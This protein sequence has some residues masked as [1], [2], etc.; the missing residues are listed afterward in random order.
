MH[1]MNP[2]ASY[3]LA[4]MRYRPVATL[5]FVA[6]EFLRRRKLQRGAPL[7]RDLP[8]FDASNLRTRFAAL[9]PD[10]AMDGT[11]FVQ[12]HPE[13]AAAI[14]SEAESIV[15]REFQVFG[16][17][18]RFAG[19]R[20]WHR[21]WCSRH[22]WPAEQ[23]GK[24]SLVGASPGA[25]IKR[26]WEIARFHFAL[27]LGAAYRV[28]RGARFALAFAKQVRDWIA[29]NPYARGIHWAMPME[30]AIRGANWATAAALFSDAPELA[31]EFWR[32]FLPALFL[33]GRHVA[34]HAEWNPVARGNHYLA[35]YAGL[36]LIA[37]AFPEQEEAAAWLED[38]RH[39]LV[40]EIQHQ[41][42]P[43]GVAHE[44]SSSYHIFLTELF[45]HAAQVMLR[46][47]ACRNGEAANGASF[48][49]ELSDGRL[50]P[51]ISAR[52][53]A[54]FGFIARLC[55][56]R[57]RPPNWGDRDD[58]RFLPFAAGETEPAHILLAIG[59]RAF[60]RPDWLH[61]ATPADDVAAEVWFRFGPQADRSASTAKDIVPSDDNQAGAAFRNAGFYFFSGTRL[62]GSVR[63]GPQ[64]VNGWANHAH[65]D[66]LSFELCCDGDG[67][68]VDPGTFEYSGDEAARNLF[69]SSCYHNSVIVNGAEQ[70]R[71]WP[72]LL[73]RIVDDTRSRLL[74]WRADKAEVEF[75]GEHRGYLRLP[76][77]VRV[78]RQINLNRRADVLCVCDTV[79][80]TGQA[81][82]EWN[83]HLA[84]GIGV[85]RIERPGDAITQPAWEAGIPT[86][87]LLEFRAAW[88]IG[89][90]LLRLWTPPALAGF[91]SVTEA[92][93]V[94][95]LYGRR[96]PAQIL[97]WSAEAVL[98]AR[99]VFE[100]SP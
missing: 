14:L 44:G 77:R 39:A 64:G 26:P 57:R 15:Q 16:E 52:L 48:G 47:A 91:T 13:S 37:A 74:H 97:R 56:G 20:D 65:C 9:M 98:P 4:Q 68:I 28:T 82:L 21:D 51:V 70:N 80:G 6:G 10:G 100:I 78:S 32:Q 8:E 45:F 61:A 81:R 71:F 58:G 84:P 41:V 11:G 27:R 22:E 19:G 72:G 95:P 40:E 88:R 46:F 34:T 42:K 29:S 1:A 18:V 2:L 63:C 59:S 5:Q 23:P 12:A 35:C 60:N 25:D 49:D 24:L 50:D 89:R 73:F 7:E 85:E 87:T 38:A 66:Q 83:L 33:H 30:V 62:R 36:L 76:Q 54:M 99:I 96:Q 94:A 90:V 17:R 55:L 43:D 86:G 92:G 79:A 75:H 67:V 93:W 31:P 53:A 3:L 69:R